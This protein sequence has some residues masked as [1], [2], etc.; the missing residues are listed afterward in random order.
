LIVLRAPLKGVAWQAETKA[1][2]EQ[3]NCAQA[4]S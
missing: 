3:S 2:L 4:K 1:R